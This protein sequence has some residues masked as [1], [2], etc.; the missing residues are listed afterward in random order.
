M[1]DPVRVLLVV[2]EVCWAR[3]ST[4]PARTDRPCLNRDGAPIANE[5]GMHPAVDGHRNAD[6]PI[7]KCELN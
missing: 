3:I 7:D 5:P 6:L 2:L 4:H 1:Q